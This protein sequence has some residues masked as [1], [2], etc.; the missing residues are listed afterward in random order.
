METCSSILHH[1]PV[2]LQALV[3]LTVTRLRRFR[4]KPKG[5][6]IASQGLIDGTLTLGI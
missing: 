4:S 3:F 2:K 1:S 6:G 5:L